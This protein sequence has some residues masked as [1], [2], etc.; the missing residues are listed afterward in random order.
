VLKNTYTAITPRRDAVVS[1]FVRA[2]HPLGGAD[3]RL[4]IVSDLALGEHAGTVVGE[5]LGQ[6]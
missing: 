3:E 1:G 5:E 6:S 4:T 2:D